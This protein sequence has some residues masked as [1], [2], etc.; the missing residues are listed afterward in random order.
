M[1]L[2]LLWLVSNPKN[3]PNQKP[4][5]SASSGWKYGFWS[6]LQNKDK[7]E[8]TLCGQVIS[9]GIKRLNQH[10][11]EAYGDAKLCLRLAVD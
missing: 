5:K 2:H 6:D 8:C 1:K 11:A 4:R 9:G 10:L 3:D 7:V